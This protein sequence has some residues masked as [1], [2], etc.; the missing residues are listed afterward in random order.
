VGNVGYVKFG[1][2]LRNRMI[3]DGVTMS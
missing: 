1:V 3:G 2:A